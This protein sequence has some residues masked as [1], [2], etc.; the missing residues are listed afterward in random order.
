MEGVVRIPSAFSMTFGVVPSITATHELVVPRSIPMTLAMVVKSSLLRQV[1]QAPKA[2]KIQPPLSLSISPGDP[3][4][5]P[6]AHIGGPH[7][8]ARQDWACKTGM[9]PVNAGLAEADLRPMRW[10]TTGQ[11]LRRN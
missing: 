2:P 11:V 10:L 6:L 8:P 3:R 9:G 7:R 5:L 1:G 4:R